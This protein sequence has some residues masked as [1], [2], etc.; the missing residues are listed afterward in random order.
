MKRKLSFVLALTLAL[1]ALPLSS[2]G[3]GNV[4]RIASWDEY[5]DEGGE[6]SYL[7][8][9]SMIDDF[10]KWY[11]E[12]T[13]KS[14]DVQY[15]PLSDNEQMY[16]KID[17]F[18]RHYDLLCPSEYMFMKLAD[19]N[20][21]EEY[22]AEFF[23]ATIEGNYYA[24]NVTPFIKNTFEENTI[25]GKPWSAYA[26]G[27][28]WGT[29]G[30]IYNTAKVSEEEVNTWTVYNNTTHQI[31]AKNNVRD[32][33]F[34][35]LGM[36]YEQDLLALKQR[37]ENNLI[38]E[39]EYKAEISRM[40]N[41][42]SPTTMDAVEKLLVNMKKGK[43]FW[44]FETDNAKSHLVG[45]DIDI[46]YQWS[47]DA[48]CVMDEAEDP[49]LK[50]PIEFS[51]CVPEAASNLW[52]DGWVMMKGAN[53]E[54]ATMFVNF[55]SM[56]ENV[57]RNMYYIGYTSCV[58]GQEVFEYVQETYGAQQGEE[59]VSYYDL[60]AYFGAGMGIWAEDAQ[61]SRQLFA[62]YPTKEVLARCCTMS[63]FKPEENNR[64]NKLW[65]DVQGA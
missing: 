48:V 58:G 37:F 56:P 51:Y 34:A 47:G 52:F 2:C 18:G 64:A 60:S 45:G 32:S 53:V 44:G 41:D 35:G 6:D 12:Q 39:T 63:Y 7:G 57:I 24:Q 1:C 22:P 5:I 16:A 29:T 11:R 14:I 43:S 20:R 50:N 15:I 10:K 26:A 9:A 36:Y 17:K 54:A 25:G 61:F 27:Y 55:L 38:S 42:T 40:M 13:G 59:G 19:E 21:L 3:D 62:Q 23:D 28:M 65:K 49:L 30:F 46:S 8:G 33:Y 4:L 31:S